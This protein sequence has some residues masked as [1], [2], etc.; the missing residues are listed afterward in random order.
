MNVERT[1]EG[2]GV[3]GPYYRGPRGAVDED[4]RW[5]RGRAKGSIGDVVGVGF[6]GVAKCLVE[7]YRCSHGDGGFEPDAECRS[8][9]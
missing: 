4:K 3:W 5:V 2:G 1:R 8:S 9:A 6:V 7:G